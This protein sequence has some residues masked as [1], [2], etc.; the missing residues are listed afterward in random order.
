MAPGPKSLPTASS[1]CRAERAG[2]SP[3]A[4][5]TKTT[6]SMSI[7]LSYLQGP[8]RV[9]SG[10][11]C[12]LCSCTIAAA[13]LIHSPGLPAKPN[14]STKNSTVVGVPSTLSSLGSVST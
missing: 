13:A 5:S 11:L 3:M 9:G 2:R 7:K 10:G 1:Y 4:G 14:D 8:L 6:S 12:A